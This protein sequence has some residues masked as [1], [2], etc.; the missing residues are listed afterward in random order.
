MKSTESWTLYS[1]E[2]Q[3]PWDLRRVVHLHRRAAFAATWDE[4]QRDLHDGPTVSI[5]R[6]LAGTA[7]FHAPA[8]FAATADLLADSAV[9]AGDINR[10]RASWFYRIVFGPDPL[11]ERLTLFWHNHFATGSAKV[12]DVGAMRQQNELFRR[13][14]RGPFAD[15]L[16]AAVRDPALL[17]YLDA[18]TNRRG[19]PNENLARELMELFTLGVGHFSEHDVKEAARALTGWTVVD[20]RFAESAERHDAEEKSILNR[21][22]PW[23][24]S[25]LVNILLDQPAVS[26]RL[27]TK[28]CGLFFGETVVPAD[29]VQSLAAGLRE[30]RLDVGWAVATILRSERFFA[31]DNVG[32]R[33]LG[34]V[35]FI[36]GAARAL[37]MFDPAPSTLALADWSA[38]MGQN[39][40]DP[41]N[42][43][44][45]PGGRDWIN[46][47][48][49]LLRTNFA[50]ALVGGAGMGGL[51]AYDAE[52]LARRHGA[53]E[54]S[55]VA[56]HH[57]L[58]FGS[59]PTPEM[60]TRLAGL[61]ARQAVAMLLASPQAQVG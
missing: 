58:L 57:R 5:N 47:R 14:G 59:D 10:L 50:E 7:S 44:G 49:M 18:Q 31:A 41:P 11:R 45:W 12:R 2:A 3:S 13:L 34:P 37:E 40:F 35:D 54:E 9:A 60:R 15:L 28:L 30:R 16:N 46:P 39:L 56:F 38:R 27:A 48:T 51:Q 20:G 43:G 1:P 6:L 17:V 53:D 26:V 4:L 24:G 36:A 19:H 22:G 25:D 8:D 23:N 29:A 33:V 42:V 21:R 61:P 32:Q 52:A 55:V